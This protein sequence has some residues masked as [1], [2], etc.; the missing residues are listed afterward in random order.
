MVCRYLVGRALGVFVIMLVARVA[1]SARG[2]ETLVWW[3]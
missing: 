1:A 2:S 3:S